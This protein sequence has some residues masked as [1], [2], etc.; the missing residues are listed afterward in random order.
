MSMSVMEARQI[1]YEQKMEAD[2]YRLCDDCQD[3]AL[4]GE[5]KRIGKDYLCETCY[6]KLPLCF[7]CGNDMVNI[8]GRDYAYCSK[9]DLEHTF[10]GKKWSVK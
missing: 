6:A 5:L 8:K 9:C 4:L 1:A 3:Y 2:G 10:N 7:D